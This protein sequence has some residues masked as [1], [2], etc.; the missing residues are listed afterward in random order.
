MFEA[1]RLHGLISRF[2]AT[3]LKSCFLV[4]LQGGPLKHLNFERSDFFP[5]RFAHPALFFPF[6]KTPFQS[7]GSLFQPAPCCNCPNAGQAFP[8]LFFY[9]L[10]CDPFRLHRVCGSPLFSFLWL[11]FILKPELSRRP[12]VYPPCR[13]PPFP[14]FDHENLKY[15]ASFFCVF[16][17]PHEP[18]F[19]PHP[20]KK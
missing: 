1:P 20:F 4:T 18:G 2:M 15:L 17:L 3:S 13:I 14:M 19:A 10:D 12:E 5:P 8:T 6:F 16:L 7:L 11:N 9:P